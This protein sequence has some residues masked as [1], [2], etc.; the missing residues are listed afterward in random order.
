MSP[1]TVGACEGRKG[2]ERSSKLWMCVCVCEEGG[3]E[4]DVNVCVCVRKGGG[5]GM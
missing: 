5:R 4:G 1:R 2:R 3:R